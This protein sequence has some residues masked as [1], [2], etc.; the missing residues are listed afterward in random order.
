MKLPP[1]K[2]RPTTAEDC[3]HKQQAPATVATTPVRVTGFAAPSC[4]ATE[5]K[6]KALLAKIKTKA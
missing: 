4:D 6:V 2:P 3:S 1:T 5:E